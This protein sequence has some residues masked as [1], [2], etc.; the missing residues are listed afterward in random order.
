[1]RWPRFSRR[2]PPRASA[3]TRG[4]CARLVTEKLGELERTIALVTNGRRAAA[5]ALVRTDRGERMM[6][7]IRRRLEAVITASNQRVSDRLAALQQAEA[8]VLRWVT[9]GGG[10]LYLRLRRGRG[11]RQ[12]GATCAT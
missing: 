7:N 3:R 12:Y 8:N 2:T 9:V 10:V 5:L 4:N 1:M 6:E 11:G